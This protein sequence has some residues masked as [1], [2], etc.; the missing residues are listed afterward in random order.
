[1]VNFDSS[2]E[3]PNSFKCELCEKAY[4]R[5]D[6]LKVFV[7]AVHEAIHSGVIS[8]QCPICNKSFIYME[9]LKRHMD[10]DHK[11]LVYYRNA[12]KSS[13]RRHSYS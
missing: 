4:S 9:S 12:T 13:F 7:K 10:A 6:K 5:K 2:L 11:G 1:M 8:F 3:I